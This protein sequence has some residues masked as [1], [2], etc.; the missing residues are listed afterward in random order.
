MTT[1]HKLQFLV[2]LYKPEVIFND[3]NIISASKKLTKFL[4]L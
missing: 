2:D 3:L 1:T 4:L